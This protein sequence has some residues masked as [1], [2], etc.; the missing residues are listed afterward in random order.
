MRTITIVLLAALISVVPRPAEA[1]GFEA[2]K[3]IM[4][5]A[6]AAA[7]R[8]RSGRSSRSTRVTIVEHAVD[9]DL[10]RTAGWEDE[11]GPRHF[12]DMDAYGPYPFT[13]LPR[14]HAEAVKQ[15]GAGLRQEE[16]DAALARPGDAAPSSPRRSLL[17]QAYSRENIKLF[18]S[19]VGHYLSDAHVPFPRRAQSRRP[20]D[21]TVG[22]SLALRV[23]ALRA[24]P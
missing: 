15:H 21:R 16:R 22:H 4:D 20:A 5:R 3:D 9:P 8:R 7:A 18:S 13:A 2:H 17:K 11:E 14:D 10:W 19:V 24:L 6:I 12:L 1:W 23:R